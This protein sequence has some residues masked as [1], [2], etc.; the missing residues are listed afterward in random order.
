MKNS[1]HTCDSFF[2][3]NARFILQFCTIKRS[4]YMICRVVAAEQLLK[5]SN[6]AVILVSADELSENYPSTNKTFYLFVNTLSA[7]RFSGSSR[8]GSRFDNQFWPWWVQ[9]LFSLVKSSNS[10]ADSSMSTT[11]YRSFRLMY[12]LLVYVGEKTKKFEILMIHWLK[13]TYEKKKLFL[14]ILF[15]MI[16]SSVNFCLTYTFL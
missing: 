2:S 4:R 5:C 11:L 12:E 9:E 6:N 15:I 1:S 10:L 13:N 8:F 14:K 3:F 16:L 7:S